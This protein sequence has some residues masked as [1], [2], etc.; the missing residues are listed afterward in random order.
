MY[1]S[2]CKVDGVRGENFRVGS[3][4]EMK[5]DEC[6]RTGREVAWWWDRPKRFQVSTFRRKTTT[7]KLDSLRLLS[8]STPEPGRHGLPDGA[9]VGGRNELLWNLFSLFRLSIFSLFCLSFT[10]KEKTFL[11]AENVVKTLRNVRPER[12]FFSRMK[13]RE[14]KHKKRPAK[15]IKQKL[16]A[17]RAKW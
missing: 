5:N 13:A 1:Q 9:H 11:L 3:G 12:E 15:D 16:R 7:T 2:K 17:L 8:L 4:R 6:G 10:W 14:D